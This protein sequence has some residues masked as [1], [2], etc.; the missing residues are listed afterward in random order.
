[1]LSALISRDYAS[2]RN[3]ILP[4]ATALN[5]IGDNPIVSA[6]GEMNA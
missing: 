3:S 4:G 5:T 1:M 2:I 6:T